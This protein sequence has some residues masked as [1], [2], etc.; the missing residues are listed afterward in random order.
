MVVTEAI[1]LIVA[2]R[3]PEQISRVLSNLSLKAR[4]IPALKPLLACR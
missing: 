4:G 1:C 3:L 2:E